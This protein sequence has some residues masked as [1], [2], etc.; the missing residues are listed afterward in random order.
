M[1][2]ET[3]DKDAIIEAIAMF[4]EEHS[5]GPSLAA[6]GEI[7]SPD[8]PYGANSILWHVHQ[9]IVEDKL[10]ADF[11]PDGKMVSRSLRIPSE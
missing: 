9:L 1:R 3:P 5:Y 2:K 6:I 7:I 4:R 8:D 10:E 11:N